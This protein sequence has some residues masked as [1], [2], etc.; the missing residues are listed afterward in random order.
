MTSRKFKEISELV[1][2]GIHASFGK[3]L[4]KFFY[5]EFSKKQG[6]LAATNA[7]YETY[8]SAITNL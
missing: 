1:Q 5:Y 4:G 8:K 6:I 3:E 2:V 7:I